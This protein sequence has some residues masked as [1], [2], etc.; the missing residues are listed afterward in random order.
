MP[1]LFGAIRGVELTSSQPSLPAPLIQVSSP[2]TIP[3]GVSVK[4]T[5]RSKYSHCMVSLL[6]A[7][8]AHTEL[9]VCVCLAPAP[10]VLLSASQLDTVLS[11]SALNLRSLWLNQ[12]GR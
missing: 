4:T 7:I 10:I 12:R 6:S 2:L 3:S 9:E 11:I 1:S 5:I 8:L